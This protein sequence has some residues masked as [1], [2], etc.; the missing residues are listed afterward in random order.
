MKFSGNTA[1]AIVVFPSGKILF[2]KRKT[3][4]FK[5]YW[6]LPG[7]RIDEGETAEEAVVREVKEETGL[8]VEVVAKIG[9][10]DEKGVQDGIEYDYHATCFHVSP[11]EGETKP[12]KEEVETIKLFHPKAIPKELAFR[13][14]EMLKDYFKRKIE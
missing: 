6:A 7:G 9:E 2:I 8:T 10:Y 11:V 4:V 14:S 12:Q 1:A 3:P 13:H 5:G